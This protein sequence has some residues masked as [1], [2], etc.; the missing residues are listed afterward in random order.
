MNPSIL[1]EGEKIEVLNFSM[2]DP[3]LGVDVQVYA[4]LAMEVTVVVQNA[5]KMDFNLGVAG[6]EDDCLRSE[7]ALPAHLYPY[8]LFFSSSWMKEMVAAE[9]DTGLIRT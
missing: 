6:F 5:W 8:F 2:Q 9:L 7:S 3:L 1:E 4:K